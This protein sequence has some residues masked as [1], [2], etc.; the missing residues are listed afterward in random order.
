MKNKKTRV[1]NTIATTEMEYNN[2]LIYRFFISTDVIN[3]V[4]RHQLKGNR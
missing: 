2:I 4:S 3:F 1:T